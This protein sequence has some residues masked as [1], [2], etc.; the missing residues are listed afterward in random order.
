MAEPERQRFEDIEDRLTELVRVLERQRQKVES[1]SPEFDFGP[2]EQARRRRTSLLARLAAVGL[3]RRREEELERAADAGLSPPQTAS[4]VSTA[5]ILRRIDELER[6][7]R[8]GVALDQLDEAFDALRRALGLDD[9]ATGREPEPN[10]PEQ[11]EGVR[12][13]DQHDLTDAKIAAA[14]AR[15]D[16][17]IA[18]IDGKLDLVVAKLDAVNENTTAL[19]REVKESERSVKAN[20][21]V[22]FGALLGSIVVVIG[23]LV[24]IMPAIFDIGM[25]SREAL[26]K[27]VHDQ[28]EM[29][30]KKSP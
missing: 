21:W 10:V 18:R 17:K 26:T 9:D 23:I 5:D 29:L 22:I 16:T 20:S 24:T 6:A 4:D 8:T 3:G 2:Q 27:E 30:L 28:L 1:N 12:V 15:T 13:S 7:L 14:E 19:R 25:R 11:T